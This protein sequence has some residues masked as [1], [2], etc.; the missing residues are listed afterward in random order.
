MLENVVRLEF[1][2]LSLPSFF[3]SFF[4]FLDTVVYAL[5]LVLS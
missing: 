1:V 4:S 2:S 3:L 5:Y